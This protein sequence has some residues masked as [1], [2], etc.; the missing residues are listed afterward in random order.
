MCRRN[1]SKNIDTR[2]NNDTDPRDAFKSRRPAKLV[3][4][5]R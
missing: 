1:A 5:F 2:D 4:R 3:I